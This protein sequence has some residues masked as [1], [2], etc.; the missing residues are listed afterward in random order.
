MLPRGL[1]NNNPL[2]VRKSSQS[3]KGKLV[4]GSDPAFEQFV[5]LE[6]GLRCAFIIL[7]T[8]IK[9]Y[10]C[11]TPSAII[12]RWA[13]AVENDVKAYVRSVE[14]IT[15]LN[16]NQR[17]KFSEKNA[18]CL[19]VWAMAYVENGQYISFGRVENAYEM[20]RS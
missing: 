7:R 19:L 11:D 8:Y 13:P 4:P 18:I 15:R 16:R 6:Y 10:R 14:Q 17:L 1:R 20:V 9:K 5:S 12:A 3:W 2:N